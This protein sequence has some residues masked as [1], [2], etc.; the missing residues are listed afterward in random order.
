[1]SISCGALHSLGYPI[2]RQTLSEDQL[3]IQNRFEHCHGDGIG[4]DSRWSKKYFL[5]SELGI[6]CREYLLP[7]DQLG[8]ICLNI[9][10]HR[11]EVS[12]KKQGRLQKI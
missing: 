8:S 10:L 9:S 4:L 1:M 6:Q 2:G 3:Q 5:V 7:W 11:E 12:S